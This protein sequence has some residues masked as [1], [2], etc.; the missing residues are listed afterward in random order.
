MAITGDIADVQSQGGCEGALHAKVPVLVPRWT[1]TLRIAI[2]DGPT[3]GSAGVK[4]GIQRK[5]EERRLLV[6]WDAIN[7]GKRRTDAVV[8]AIKRRPS[9]ETEQ[10]GSGGPAGIAAAGSLMR[11]VHHVAAAH[12]R[13]T[14]QTV[15]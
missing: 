3:L 12:D 15:G 13:L 11:V 2:S 9:H 8:Q 4:S 10:P 7:P 1:P 14:V 6:G 5:I